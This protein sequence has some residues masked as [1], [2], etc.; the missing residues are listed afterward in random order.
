MSSF[1]FKK[2]SRKGKIE[3]ETLDP[4][5][6]KLFLTWSKEK[7][8]SFWKAIMSLTLFLKI[9]LFNGNGFYIILKNLSLFGG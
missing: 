6:D 1:Y 3:I 2:L 9:K 5:M 8:I 7:Q 4:K